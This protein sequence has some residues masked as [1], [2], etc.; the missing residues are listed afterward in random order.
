MNPVHNHKVKSSSGSASSGRPPKFRE[1][2]RPIT[3]TL[4]ERILQKLEAMN[5]DRAQAIV[6]CV[7]TV[8]GNDNEPIK[9]V[10]LVKILPGKAMIIVGPSRLLGKAHWLRR[11]EISPA[12]YLLVLP[13][14]MTIESMELAI[15]ELMESLDDKDDD[16]YILLK[17]LRKIIS[18]QRRQ[19]TVSKGEL[20]FVSVPK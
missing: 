14:G 1:A 13:S 18:Y 2:R 11:I 8:T 5:P 7:E 3:V 6:K 12:R 20:V 9:P 15:I 17:E 16:E 10:E 19:N 4:P